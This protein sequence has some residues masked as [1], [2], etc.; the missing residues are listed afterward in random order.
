MVEFLGEIG[1]IWETQYL[2]LLFFGQK[3]FFFLQKVFNSILSFWSVIFIAV[4][5]FE[6]AGAFLV[7]FEIRVKKIYSSSL[8]PQKSHFPH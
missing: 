6:I 2:N 5:F 4:I 8:F 7:F 1:L 3:L